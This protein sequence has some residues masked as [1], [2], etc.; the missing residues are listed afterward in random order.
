MPRLVTT[1]SCGAVRLGY[2]ARLPRDPREALRGIVEATGNEANG[3]GHD[4]NGEADGMAHKAMDVYLNDHLGGATLGANLA[5]QIA[6][7]AE[8]TPLADVMTRLHAEIDED[9]ETLIALM[10]RMDVSRNPVKQATGWLAE[11]A[12]RVKFSGATSGESDHGLFMALESMALGV[13]GKLS[14]WRALR[15]VRDDHPELAA[16]DLDALIVRAEDQYA[17]LERERLAVGRKAL[18]ASPAA[19]EPQS[20]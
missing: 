10:E 2:T 20:R 11:A 18:A 8:G 1:S 17:T 15:E 4:A 5:E 7:H 9:R 16:M 3:M 12:S 6:D 13:Q 14:L 19:A